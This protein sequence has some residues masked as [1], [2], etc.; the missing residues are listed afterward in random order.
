MKITA[1][2]IVLFLFSFWGC[3]EKKNI[4]EENLSQDVFL[5]ID[6][7]NRL[8]LLR[9]K[10]EVHQNGNRP[11]ELKILNKAGE[12]INERESISFDSLSQ[13]DNLIRVYISNLTNLA[14]IKGVDS[15]KISEC[16]S[17]L[18]NFFKNPSLSGYRITYL[19]LLL[20]ENFI[21]Q[22]HLLEISQ[23]CRWFNKYIKVSKDN[24][25]INLGKQY[26][27]ALVT[28][29]EYSSISIEVDSI[30]KIKHNGKYIFLPKYIEKIGDVLVI[31]LRPNEKGAYEIEGTIL[32]KHKVKSYK[33]THLFSDKFYV[34]E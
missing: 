33:M 4:M 12:I 11:D 16:R 5:Y 25:T 21:L 31:K 24:D 17:I 2:L 15:I 13:K 20:M 14:S 22:N 29:V 28:G 32:F 34:K 9:I 7:D 27:F 6:H 1:L 19:N 3:K 26:S 30:F 23:H 8:T 10:N 18:H